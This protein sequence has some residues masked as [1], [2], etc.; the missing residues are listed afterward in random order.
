MKSRLAEELK[1]RFHP[2]AIIFTNDEP[3]EALQFKEG[4]WGCVVEMVS[5]VARGRTAIFQ[6]K[7]LVCPG[8][9]VGMCLADGFADSPVE[10][11]LSTGFGERHVEG[12]KQLE[13]EDRREAYRDGIG[14]LK[15]PS[16]AKD[17]MDEYPATEIPFTYTLLKPLQEVD[18]EKETPQLVIFLANADQLTALVTLA[19]FD[20]SGRE[21]VIIPN[22]SACQSM[23]LFPY[24]EAQR[25]QPR[26]VV[27]LLDLWARVRADADV[28]SFTVPFNMFLRM[29]ANVPESFFA[30]PVWRKIRDRIP[31]P[32]S[33]DPGCA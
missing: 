2:M 16:L 20:R 33:P 18:P 11:F 13:A 19:G 9:K 28:L 27:G 7:T 8:G 21:N 24:R 12:L 1:L 29:E 4:I 25:E 30:R 15:T 10:L 3:E 5:A 14:Y 22:L 26:A 32:A 17:R 23:C 31:E 6:S